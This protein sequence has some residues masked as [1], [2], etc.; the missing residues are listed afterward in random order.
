MVWLS[1]TLISVFAIALRDV[2]R[3]KISGPTG[4][5]LVSWTRRLGA[6]PFLA[7]VV[8]FAHVPRT[9][10][11][12]HIVTSVPIPPDIGA[13]VLYTKAIRISPFNATFPF[14]SLT[15]VFVMLDG[16]VPG[17]PLLR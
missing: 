7:P 2:I 15:P 3:R 6:L 10:A 12:F 17:T 16:S 5:L 9:S 11:E 4:T 1:L 8:P 13:L 14:L